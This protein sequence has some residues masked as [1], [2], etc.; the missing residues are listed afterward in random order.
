MRASVSARCWRGAASHHVDQTQ[1]QHQ[2]H[3]AHGHHHKDIAESVHQIPASPHVGF[4]SVPLTRR[5]F[6]VF[7]ADPGS[8]CR[9]GCTVCSYRSG[10][11]VRQP[12]ASAKAGRA[13]RRLRVQARQR[14]LPSDCGAAAIVVARPV[15][16]F[17]DGITAIIAA[18]PVEPEHA[19]GAGKSRM[20]W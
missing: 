5:T 14:Q 18:I 16:H 17:I 3:G 4:G 8:R 1:Q 19:I 11:C 10:R 6:D 2:R 13:P 7:T 20:C 15:T 9:V 12:P